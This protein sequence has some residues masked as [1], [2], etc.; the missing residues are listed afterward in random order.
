MSTAE[1]NAMGPVPDGTTI[2]NMTPDRL[3][4][5]RA[6]NWYTALTIDPGTGAA[7]TF[8]ADI[9]MVGGEILNAGSGGV[10]AGSVSASFTLPELTWS[11]DGETKIMTAGMYAKLGDWPTQPGDGSV[12]MPL[13]GLYM[14]TFTWRPISGSASPV[15]SGTAWCSRNAGTG[16][17]ASF[18][19]NQIQ[20]TLTSGSNVSCTFIAEVLTL[21]T[22]LWFKAAYHLPAQTVDAHADIIYQGP[23]PI[24]I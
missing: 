15:G 20:P 7:S 10:A 24:W 14:V 16:Y 3:E 6:G 8:G 9:D 1:R 23:R 18:T 17:A 22:V 4:T 2:Y 21:P 11:V 5:Y 13:E 19:Q 12:A